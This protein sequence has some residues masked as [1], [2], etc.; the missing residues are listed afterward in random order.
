M[1]EKCSIGQNE[2]IGD[3]LLGN[4]L[5]YLFFPRLRRGDFRYTTILFKAI[6]HLILNRASRGAILGTQQYLSKQFLI[7]FLFAPPAR[8]F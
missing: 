6:P 8:R 2:K 1:I 4:A 5:P 3:I 7:E